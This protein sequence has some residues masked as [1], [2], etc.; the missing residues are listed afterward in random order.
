MPNSCGGVCACRSVP[1]LSLGDS[2]VI[3]SRTGHT[4]R[5]VAETARDVG[6]E[7][8]VDGRICRVTGDDLEAVLESL[9]VALSVT[10]LDEARVVLA[11]IDAAPDLLAVGMGALPLGELVARLRHRELATLLADPSRFY[12][13]FQPIV[14][15]S[16][17]A[18][19]AFESLLRAH[20]TDGGEVG[21]LDLFPPAAATGTTHILDRIGRETAIRDAAED[22]GGRELFINFVPTSIYRPELCLAT[23]VAAAERHGVP[24]DRLVF[25]VTETEQVQQTSHLLH[26]VRYYREQGAKVALDDVGSGY[27]S[28]EL[29]Q[30]LE[31]DVIKIDRSIIARLPSPGAVAVVTALVT[32]GGEFGGRVLA[33]GVETSQEAA[34]ARDLGVD[35]A[36]GWF[37]GRPELAL[38]PATAFIASA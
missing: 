14:T 22:L 18:T 37:F 26:I 15:L 31:P 3:H 30:A 28:I 24:L 21:A 13:R 7:A 19:V 25:E 34:V 32:I 8:S 38:Q 5:L 4:L 35:L 17:G 36:Q 20:G 9:G 23:T 12:A 29:V 1:D 2:L 33:E 6:V 10:E 11:P 16:D 27:A